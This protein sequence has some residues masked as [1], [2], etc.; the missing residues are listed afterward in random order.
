ME[1][2][3]ALMRR[4][5]LLIGS[6]FLLSLLLKAQNDNARSWWNPAQNDFNVIEGQGWSE[7]D[8]AD[9]NRLPYSAK[10]M[11]ANDV[12]GNSTHAAGLMVRFRSNSG[13][14]KVRYQVR[15][16]QNYGM[17]HMPASGK[18]GVDLYAIDSDGNELWC[19]GLRN[20][21]DT[22]TYSYNL[23]NPNDSYHKFGREY[24]LYLPL[25]NHVEWLE[26]GVSDTTYF[27]ALPVRQELPIVVYGTSIAHGACASRPG[28]AWTSILSR[29]LDR[30][31]INLGFSGSG[32]LEKPV[33]DLV[34]EIDA[35]VYILDCLPNLPVHAWKRNN[36]KSGAEVKLRILKAV[37]D[38]RTTN[39]STPILLTEHAGYTEEY[40][41]DIRKSHFAIVNQ[42]QK[43]AFHQ[44]KNEGIRNLYYLSKEEIGLTMDDMVDGTH[45]TDLGMF[46]YAQAYENKLRSILNEP[47]GKLSTTQPCTQAREPYNYNWEERHRQILALNKSDA[48]KTVIFANSI[49]HFWGGQPISKTAREEDTWSNY[50]T[51]LGV[52]N[53]AYGW[54]RIENVLWRVYHGELDG[55]SAERIIVMIGTNNLH[56]NT[57]EEI[58]EGMDLLIKAIKVRQPEA[59]IT[60]V[61]ILPRRKY[62]SRIS[63][64]NFQIADL[65]ANHNV[66]YQDIGGELL[67][68]DASINESYFSDGL[69]PN[70]EGYIL[71]RDNMI[72]LCNPDK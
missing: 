50:L 8:I 59:Q 58:I 10:G 60:M 5:F 54:D 55:Y 51:P 6:F 66:L 9:Y 25:Y 35:K 27:E 23:L 2:N 52:R 36:I 45:P 15:D 30:P 37:R 34:S 3:I 39:P 57:N 24:R 13:A 38:L 28:M 72:S 16:R 12:W 22:I 26:I 56:L 61:G 46:H 33:I 44:L 21:S 64:I 29:N 70:K 4:N 49:V 48:P 47:T 71:L 18:S 31:L 32:R 62:E 40:I 63:Q 7:E 11:V 43:E 14:I 69:H 53:Q 65:A 41:S 68:P 1:I 42:I 67:N 17:E 20:F 19:K